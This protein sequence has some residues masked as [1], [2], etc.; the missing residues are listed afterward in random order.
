MELIDFDA[1]A[2]LL[3][4]FMVNQLLVESARTY[5]QS[6]PEDV[7]KIFYLYYDFGQS[8]SEIAGALAITES[9]V[10]NK[11]YRTL[12]ELRNLLT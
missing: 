12:K 10:K 4:D 1:D 5:I 6:K 9:S 8:L 2:F 11:L 3:E 7:K